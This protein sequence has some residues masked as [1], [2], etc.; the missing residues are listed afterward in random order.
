MRR[1]LIPPALALTLAACG[2]QT[3]T[4]N[5]AGGWTGTIQYYGLTAPATLQLTQAANSDTLSGT[6]T[7]S[8][9]SFPVT[10]KVSTGVLAFNDGFFTQTLTGTFTATTY[11]GTIAYEDQTGPFS[12]SRTQ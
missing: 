9:D 1:L 2:A 3:P 8:G 5:V 7:R 4:L 11:Q 6:I 12:F 10:G